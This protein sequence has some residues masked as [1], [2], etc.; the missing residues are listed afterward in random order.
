MISEPGFL[1]FDSTAL[2]EGP[3]YS[4][5]K[6]NILRRRQAGHDLYLFS[7]LHSEVWLGGRRLL[8]F[9]ASSR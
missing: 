3:L 1:S 2:R 8:F 5:E 6:E 9:R 7:Y 4:S